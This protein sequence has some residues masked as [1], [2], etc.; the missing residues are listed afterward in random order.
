MSIFYSKLTGGFY[1]DAIHRELPSDAVEISKIEYDTLISD[2]AAGC[3]IKADVDGKPISKVKHPI[4]ISAHDSATAELSDL[5]KQSSGLLRRFLVAKFKEDPL[6]PSELT[7][8][9]AAAVEA[10]GRLEP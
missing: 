5:D 1:D 7:E 8:Y 10:R 2:Q 4:A 3:E 6:F 9:E